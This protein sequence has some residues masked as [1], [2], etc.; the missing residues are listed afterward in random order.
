[1]PTV[2]IT[3]W[4]YE[5][6]QGGTQQ[7]RTPQQQTKPDPDLAR[8]DIDTRTDLLLVV[9]K[10]GVLHWGFRGD[11]CNTPCQVVC[12]EGRQDN[13]GFSLSCQLLRGCVLSCSKIPSACRADITSDHIPFNLTVHLCP[14]QP[15]RLAKKLFIS[16]GVMHQ[17][18][19]IQMKKLIQGI[20]SPNNRK[21]QICRLLQLL[22]K[23]GSSYA[24]QFGT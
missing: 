3:A 16:A 4:G 11:E 8:W 9:L 15:C 5:T 2:L 13:S 19:E 24:V 21:F 10:E 23:M 14:Y 22:G 20:I 1:M 6:W 17:G 12:S 7:K 18:G